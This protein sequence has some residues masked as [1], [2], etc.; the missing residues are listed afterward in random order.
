MPHPTSIALDTPLSAIQDLYIQYT[1]FPA[2]EACEMSHSSNVAV[3][4]TKILF[5][6]CDCVAESDVGKGDFLLVLVTYRV[7]A[8]PYVIVRVS[9]YGMKQI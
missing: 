4:I 3:A 1:E 5:G 2:A 8:C 9:G 6:M 7:W